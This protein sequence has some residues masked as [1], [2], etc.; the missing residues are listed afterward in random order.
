[1]SGVYIIIPC[2]N[3][4][5]TIVK[6]IQEIENVLKDQSEKCTVVIVDDGSADNTLDLLTAMQVEGNINLKVIT[7][8]YNVGHQGAIAQGL[9]Y[10]NDNKA[11]FSI[12]MD[13][14]GE[15][16][17]SALKELLMLR[18]YD[19]VHV[20]RGK[21]KEKFSFR[22][23]YNIYR[24]LFRLITKKKMNFGNYCMISNRVVSI[25]SS[26]TFIHFAAF[27]SKLQ[28][29]S[30]RII[31]DRRSRIGGISKMN[32]TG[33]IHHAFRS[34]AEYGEALLMVFLRLFVILFVLFIATICYIFYLKIFTNAAI[35][36]WSSTFGIGLLTSALLCMGFFVSGVLLLNISQ[37]RAHTHPVQLYKEVR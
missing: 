2:Y 21:R 3:E 28:F 13:G 14:D 25:A 8:K 37:Y 7:L 26:K 10:A 27:L 33:L 23:A 12:V 34:F 1:M 18:Q 30:H 19:I 36:G 4:G 16:D 29:K 24:R 17:P 11:T 32:I 9:M 6:L 15:D 22:I 5:Q 20:V 31:Y 35:L